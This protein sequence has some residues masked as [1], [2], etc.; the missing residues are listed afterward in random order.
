MIKDT[1]IETVTELQ[2][3][4]MCFRQKFQNLMTNVLK[5]ALQKEEEKLSCVITAYYEIAIEE[6]MVVRAL[7][8]HNYEWLQFVWAFDKNYIGSRHRNGLFISFD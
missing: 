4:K 3:V 8:L 6:D 7:D 1:K 5:I 2:E